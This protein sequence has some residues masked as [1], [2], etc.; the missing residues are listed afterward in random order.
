M[1][2]ENVTVLDVIEDPSKDLL[3]TY[4]ADNADDDI[5]PRL[6]PSSYVTE[7][8]LNEFLKVKKISDNGHIKLISLNIANVLSKL[9][10]LKIMINNVSNESNKPSFI[11]LTETHLAQQRCQGYSESELKCLLPGY[12][13]FHKDRKNKRG[14]GVGI[15]VSKEFSCNAE[16][17]TENCFFEDE[18]FES[19]TL[20][21]PNFLLTSGKKNLIILTLYRQPGNENLDKFFSLLKKWLEKLIKIQ[22]SWS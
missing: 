13:F 11:T 8:E 3:N 9:S 20:K 15:F 4:F 12:D 2:Q 5:V 21:I 7:T 19:I 17:D 10:S 14:G 18:F 1:Q 22:M 6:N 16:I